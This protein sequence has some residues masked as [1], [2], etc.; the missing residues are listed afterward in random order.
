LSALLA[1]IGAFRKAITNFE[2]EVKVF[3][4]R[5][6][7]G[8]RAVR[9]ARI[10]DLHV[11]LV[12]NFDTL[13][14]YKK[15]QRMDEVAR[16]HASEY[17][18]DP[19]RDLPSE[20]VTQ[21]IGAFLSVLGSDG[22]LE[23]NLAS[24]INLRG[25]VTDNGVPKVFM[26]ESEF[27]SISSTGLTTL[28]KVTLMTGLLNT[29]RDNETVYIPWVT[30]EVGTIDG[31]NFVALMQMLRDNW[32]DVMTASPDL[33][34]TQ[35]ALFARRYLFEDRG[36]V[37]EYVPAGSLHEP[38]AADSASINAGGDIEVLQ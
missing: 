5:L 3:N 33:G 36:R 16:H 22:A 37:R 31:G 19:S 11:D 15:L 18:K 26:R 12:T 7:T 27:E 13:G 21:A 34:P 24:H 9:F 38:Q 35:H 17:G 10:K 29:I 8:L 30:D 20:D 28:I 6:G 23:V 1:N 2:H 25:R 32:I 4:E 14:F